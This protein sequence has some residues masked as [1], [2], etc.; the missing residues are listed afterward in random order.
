M[1]KSDSYENRAASD[2]DAPDEIQT[3]DADLSGGSSDGPP[4][5]PGS[6]TPAEKTKLSG[7]FK[8]P[9]TRRTSIPLDR[10]DTKASED[11]EEDDEGG[12]SFWT[13]DE[14]PLA[15][16]SKVSQSKATV[17]ENSNPF[18]E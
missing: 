16:G 9:D 17:F 3:A 13:H 14:A 12:P 18:E 2:N 15:A 7:W 5:Q 4:V 8:K 11:A 6:K 10:T 1:S